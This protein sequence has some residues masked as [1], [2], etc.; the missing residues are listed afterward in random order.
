MVP[1]ATG[2]KN[3]LSKSTVLA[4]SS[5][6]PLNEKYVRMTSIVF[7]DIYDKMKGKNYGGTTFNGYNLPRIID[8]AKI[9]I[10][11]GQGVKVDQMYLDCNIDSKV[12]AKISL[13]IRSYDQRCYFWRKLNLWDRMGNLNLSMNSSKPLIKEIELPLTTLIARNSAEKIKT[14]SRWSWDRNWIQYSRRFFKRTKEKQPSIILK[15]YLLLSKTILSKLI[16]SRSR[17]A[18]SNRNKG[19]TSIT[20]TSGP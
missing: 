10:N 1:G 2:N 7:Q 3:D 11:E 16:Y 5:A 6:A 12:S 20:K 9:A 19:I 4:Q 17:P 8:Q 15:F 14:L 18:L 13:R